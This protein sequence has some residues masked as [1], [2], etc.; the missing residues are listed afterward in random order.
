MKDGYRVIDSDLH[1]IEPG[2]V[3][4]DYLDERYR[5][6]GPK[7]LGLGPT[8]FPQ[9]EI[10]AEEFRTRSTGASS[11]TVTAASNSAIASSWSP[12]RRPTAPTPSMPASS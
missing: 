11:S 4:E 3:F 9:W 8:P 2:A 7:F 1:V 12:P 5:E 6:T 10:Q